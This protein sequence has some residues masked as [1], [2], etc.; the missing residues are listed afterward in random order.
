[1]LLGKEARI[2]TLISSF[3]LLKKLSGYNAYIKDQLFATLETTTKKINLPNSKIEVL[4]SDT[5][6]FIRKLPHN[7]IASFRTTLSDIKDA[8]LIIKIVDIS[9][10]DY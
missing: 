5:V 9:A 2:T 1:M 7:L 8:N 10:K 6:G 3:S 4:L